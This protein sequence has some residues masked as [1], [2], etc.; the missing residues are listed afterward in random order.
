MTNPHLLLLGAGVP[1]S[2]RP[3]YASSQYTDSLSVP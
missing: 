1:L 2:K 3:V